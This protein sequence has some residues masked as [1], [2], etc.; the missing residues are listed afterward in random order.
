LSQRLMHHP[1]SVR[2]H[3]RLSFLHGPTLDFKW[4]INR[5]FAEDRLKTTN[6]QPL[7]SKMRIQRIIQANPEIGFLDGTGHTSQAILLVDS[8][9]VQG[10]LAFEL[11]TC[12]RLLHKHGALSLSIKL[13][14][15]SV[16]A[17][18][19]NPVACR[20]GCKNSTRSLGSFPSG[21]ILHLP[22]S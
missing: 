5:Q 9:T 1:I 10:R 22:R 11:R 6:S 19:F 4:T 21:T 7:Q 3:R 15:H 2:F 17:V 18:G 12:F 8:S 20:R 14:S 13:P 16:A